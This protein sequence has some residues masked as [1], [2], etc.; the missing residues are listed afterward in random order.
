VYD[1]LMVPSSWTA[2]E[3]LQRAAWPG[4]EHRDAAV[5]DVRL[6]VA[7][8]GADPPLILLHGWSQRSGDQH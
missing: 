3:T 1:G 5:N 4:V 7:E 6:N 2:R 8:A